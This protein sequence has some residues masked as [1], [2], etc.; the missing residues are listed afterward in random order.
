MWATYSVPLLYILRTGEVVRLFDD[1]V[2]Y[3]VEVRE[4][5]AMTELKML[6][7]LSL[8]CG[9][10]AALVERLENELKAVLAI[11]IPVELVDAGT[12]PRF[13]MKAKRWV[14]V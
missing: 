4:N 6:L 11:R 9:E 3:R 7:E 2:E 5:R 8:D 13:E 14:R 1:V 10:Q 12:L